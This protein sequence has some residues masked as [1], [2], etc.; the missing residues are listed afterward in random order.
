[1]RGRRWGKGASARLEQKNAT[2]KERALSRLKRDERTGWGDKLAESG[3]EPQ[4]M[5]VALCYSPNALMRPAPRS[6]VGFSSF[7]GQMGVQLDQE[8]TGSILA[9]ALYRL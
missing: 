5:P 9:M 3:A 8:H 7:Y 4:P 2:A 1:M 6:S